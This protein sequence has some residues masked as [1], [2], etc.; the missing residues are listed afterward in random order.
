MVWQCAQCQ[1]LVRSGQS[2][3]C[4]CTRLPSQGRPA[5]GPA[6]SGLGSVGAD[7]AEAWLWPCDIWVGVSRGQ[8]GGGLPLALRHLGWGRSGP[9][10]RRPTPGRGTSGFGSVGSTGWRPAP[11]SATSGMGSVG[12]G[13][14][15]PAPRP[16][17]S[18]L[19]SVGAGRAEAWL[20]PC[21]L[22]VGVSRGRLGGGQPLAL[23][24]VGWGEL[25]LARQRPAPGTA[26]SGMGSVEADWE[27]ACLWHS[28]IWDGVSRG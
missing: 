1:L 6:T 7:R 15:G 11:R 10:G 24:H 20:W 28:A 12:A 9:A 25:G 17:T 2:E 16:T 26:P 23:G 4:P 27:E 5:P 19:G 14:A 21:D 8:L 18:G 22:W 3:A 13:R